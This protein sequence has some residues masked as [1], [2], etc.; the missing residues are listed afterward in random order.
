M[1]VAALLVLIPLAA[2]ALIYGAMLVLDV[3]RLLQGVTPSVLLDADDSAVFVAFESLLIAASVLM[4]FVLRDGV[5]RARES[6]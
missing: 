4:F 2:G 1:P 3:A 6:N 5:R